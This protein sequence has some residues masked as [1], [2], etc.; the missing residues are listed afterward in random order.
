MPLAT[1][2]AFLLQWMDLWFIRKY[3]DEASV[4][5]YAWAYTI[6]LLATN[7]LVPLAAILSPRAIDMR[8]NQD[9]EGSVKI[10]KSIFSICVLGGV[11]LPLLIS[12]LGLLGAL[13]IPEKYLESLPVLLVL[14]S[15]F[16]CQMAMSFME[17]LVYAREYLVSKMVSIV[18]VMVLIK[19][20]LNLALI[21]IIGIIG[22]AVATVMC[23]GI[24]MVLQWFLLRRVLGCNIPSPLPVFILAMIS[25]VQAF[26]SPANHL[27]AFLLSLVITFFGVFLLQRLH[28][29]ENLPPI[30]AKIFGFRIYTWLTAP[31]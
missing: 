6:I 21:P 14:S 12:G 11:F 13:W 3:F 30:F 2:G 15:V 19:A 31:H 29:S 25:M 28:W 8:I 17:P 20:A 9:E 7:V 4:G 1:L 24:G 18:V 10:A 16:L 27:L 5:Y 23:Y 26:L 22:S